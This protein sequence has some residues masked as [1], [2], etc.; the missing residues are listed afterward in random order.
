VRWTRAEIGAA[1]GRA[2][3][4]LFVALVT[5]PA[6]Y[7]PMDVGLDPSWVWGINAFSRSFGGDLAFTY[8]PLGWILFPQGSRAHLFGG[9]VFRI[10]LQVSLA[11]LVAWLPPTRGR[12]GFQLLL[13]AALVASAVLAIPLD[14]HILGVVAL[15]LAVAAASARPFAIHAVAVFCAPLWFMK[16]TLGVGALLAILGASAWA[17]CRVKGASWSVVLHLVALMACSAVLLRPPAWRWWS[18][19]LELAH[20]YS[21][22]MSSI[23]SVTLLPTGTAL[24]GIWL[25]IA[26]V[27]SARRSPS[28]LPIAVLSG[29]LFLAFKQA[30]VREDGGHIVSLFAFA[31]V[32]VGLV[33]AWTQAMPRIVGAAALLAIFVLGVQAVPAVR[34]LRQ[35]GLVASGARGA[36]ELRRAVGLGGAWDELERTGLSRLEADRL[37]AATRDRLTSGRVAVLPLELA[38]CPANGLD[39][40]P[41]PLLQQYAAYT[42]ALDSR[43]AAAV[44]DPRGPE[45]L[46]V[47]TVLDIDG[48]SVLLESPLLWTAILEGYKV[49]PRGSEPGLLVLVRDGGASSW[50]AGEMGGS[51]AALGA[52]V[53][54]PRSEG[55]IVGR[56]Q[57]PATVRGALTRALSRLPP[58]E[59]ELQSA[60]GSIA[61]YRILPDTS[62]GGLMVGC[63][64]ATLEELRVLFAGGAC[65][66]VRRL[67][68]IGDPR[69]YSRARIRWL[70][71]RRQAIVSGI[72]PAPCTRWGARAQIDRSVSRGDRV[73]LAS[74]PAGAPLQLAGWAVDETGAAASEIAIDVDGVRSFT[75]D[76]GLDRPDVGAAEGRKARRSGFAGYVP[77]EA[78]SPGQHLIS[79]RL[80]RDGKSICS[81]A[82]I[83]LS[84][85]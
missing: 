64:P 80:L 69:W 15:A 14:G 81:R 25:L 18:A 61:R 74:V 21:A 24:L 8:G 35:A 72:P 68:V 1:A 5:F 71:R 75:A 31:C 7:V 85:R 47:H 33:C 54:V 27:S 42:A 39:C 29:P 12:R 46:L 3:G 20:G 53:D 49:D 83:E 28:L 66:P 52:W 41:L 30:F 73:S 6:G 37:P 44:S 32:C 10:A 43:M 84:A 63:V 36:S 70:I 23:P 56:V 60:S 17:F 2:A 16:L 40:A 51:V 58:L 4:G 34:N 77:G 13:L 67:R 76:Y 45:R 50:T 65:D 55:L 78:L 11:L 82:P 79:F 19:N 62:P 57:I 59:L 9:A 48:R 22:A 26:I 38:F